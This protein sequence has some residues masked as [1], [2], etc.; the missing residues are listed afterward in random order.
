MRCYLCS[1]ERRERN[2]KDAKGNAKIKKLFVKNGYQLFS[3]DN[4]GLIFYDFKNNYKKFLKKQYAQ[5]YFTGKAELNSYFDY[6]KDKNNIL[7]NMR[8]YLEEI[9]KLKTRGKLLDV[10]C[11]YGYFLQ[12]ANDKG[13]EVFGIDPSDYAVK[14]AQKKFGSKIIKTFL[15][16]ADFPEKTFAVITMFDVF[17]HLKDPKSDLLK[18]MKKK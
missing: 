1:R 4:C 3:C 17:E 7:K 13:F 14:K 11:A 18:I 16:K 2:A 8:W 12:L 9:L 15:S 5:G 10:G 6:G